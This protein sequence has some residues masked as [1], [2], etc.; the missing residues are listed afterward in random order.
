MPEHPEE[1]STLEGTVSSIIFQMRTT[2]TP[3]SAW[4]QGRRR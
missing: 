2:A 1:Q 3:S 4:T